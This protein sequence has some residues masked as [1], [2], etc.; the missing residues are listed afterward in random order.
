[1]TD[2]ACMVSN[3]TPFL[4]CNALMLSSHLHRTQLEVRQDQSPR[5]S[6]QQ[7]LP[8]GYRGYL[9]VIPRPT[10]LVRRLQPRPYLIEIRKG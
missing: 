2:V 3:N 9:R 4:V 7:M 8:E 6:R 5:S 1:M 10:S